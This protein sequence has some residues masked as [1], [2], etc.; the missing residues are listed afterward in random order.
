LRT[1]RAIE[2]FSQAKCI[3]HRIGFAFPF[4]PAVGA[5]NAAARLSW[6]P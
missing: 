3:S 6:K 4:S 2:S 5:E 1:P